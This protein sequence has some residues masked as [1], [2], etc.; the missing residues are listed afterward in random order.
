M[1]VEKNDIILQTIVFDRVIT[2][3]YVTFFGGE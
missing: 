3:I 2:V 1:S